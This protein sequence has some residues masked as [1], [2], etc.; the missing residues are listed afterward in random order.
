MT[1]YVNSIMEHLRATLAND[2]PLSGY[3]VQVGRPINKRQ[4]LLPWA[5]IWPGPMDI[6]GHSITA[7]ANKPWQAMVTINIYHQSYSE[8][9][10]ETLINDMTIGQ[11]EIITAVSSNLQLD[12]AVLMLKSISG[13]MVDFDEAV[14]ENFIT[15]MLTLIYEVRG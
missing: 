8:L 6:E 13:E 9:L 4:D 14:E 5:G 15:N 7:N 11:R 12:G 2:P 1:I 10:D 3:T